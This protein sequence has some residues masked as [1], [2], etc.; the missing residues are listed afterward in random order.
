[1]RDSVDEHV[2]RWSTELHWLDPIK[3][4]RVHVRLTPAGHKAFEQ[5]AS[6]EE[7]TELAILSVLTAKERRTLA[8]LLRKLVVAIEAGPTSG[9][10]ITSPAVGKRFAPD[11]QL[12]AGSVGR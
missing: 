4:R 9:S 1:M 2:V 10:S 8:D 6:A 7:R 12:D 11:T 5:H 3:D